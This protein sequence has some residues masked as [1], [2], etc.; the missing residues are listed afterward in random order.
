[1]SLLFLA[2]FFGGFLS[3]HFLTIWHYF[4]PFFAGFFAVFAEALK[5]FAVGAPFAPG[6]RIF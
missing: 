6:L 1:V 5:A 2:T 3:S 4:F